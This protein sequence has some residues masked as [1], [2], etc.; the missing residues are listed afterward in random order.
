MMKRPKLFISGS[1][2]RLLVA[3]KSPHKLHYL[4]FKKIDIS[5]RA[6]FLG[7]CQLFGE[8]VQACLV[9]G[10]GNFCLS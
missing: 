9:L 5:L 3:E 10:V 8:C 1:F 6:I 7:L 4:T 2:G